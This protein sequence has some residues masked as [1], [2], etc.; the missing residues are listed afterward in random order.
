MVIE[1][2]LFIDGWWPSQIAQGPS[3]QGCVEAKLGTL[4]Y[5]SKVGCVQSEHLLLASLTWSPRV[6]T[7][8]CPPI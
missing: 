2:T 5:A 6:Q 3:K 1:S 8:R 7:T 4:A